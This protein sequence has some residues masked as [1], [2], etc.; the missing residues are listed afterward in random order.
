MKKTVLVVISF[1]LMIAASGCPM[2]TKPEQKPGNSGTTNPAKYAAEFLGEWI[3]MDTGDLWYI[4]GNSIKVNGAA[5]NMNV[6]LEKTSD[7]VITARGTNN[8]K[9][10]LFAS[11][12]PNASFSAEVVFLDGG[13]TQSSVSRDAIGSNGQKPPV[14]II[15]PKQPEQPPLKVQPDPVTGIIE[16]PG[17]IPGDPVIMTPDDPAWKNIN[18]RLTPG[19]GE[20]QYMGTLALTQGDN[21]KVSVRM[22]NYSAGITE[23]YADGVPREYIFEIENIA[24]SNCGDVGLKVEWDDED[25][26][27]SSGSQSGNFSNI[28]PGGKKEVRLTLIPKPIVPGYKTKEFK[29]TIRNYDSK[30]KKIRTWSDAVSVLYYK[31]PVPFR[32]KSLKTTQGI[33]KIKRDKA[34]GDGVSHYFK[35]TRTGDSGEYTATVLVPWSEEE[36]LIGFLGATIE[37]ESST[38]YS[39]GINEQPPSDWNSLDQ[40]DFLE[41]YKPDNEYEDRA[42]VLDLTAGEKTFMGFLAGDSIDYYKIRLGHVPPDYKTI[43]V[44]NWDKADLPDGY[45]DGYVNPG[46]TINLDLKFVNYTQ[47]NRTLTMTGLTPAVTH[48]AF[49]QDIRVPSY[50]LVLSAEHYG[51]LTSANTSTVS[52][53]VQLLYPPNI[54]R[55]FQFKLAPDCPIGPLSLTITFRDNLGMEYAQTVI[56]DVVAP[57]INIALDGSED[58]V[59]CGG[60]SNVVIWAKNTG[61]QDAYGVT[62][63]LVKPDS[64]HSGY[65]TINTTGT[66]SLGALSAG[67]SAASASFSVSVSSSCPAGVDIPLQIEFTNSEG[68]KWRANFSVRVLPPCPTNVRATALSENSVRISWDMVSGATNYKVYDGNSVL[69]EDVGTSTQYEHT[70]LAAATVY[71]YRVSALSS[72]NESVKSQVVS[73]KTWERLSFNREYGGTVSTGI[74]QYYRFNVTNSASYTFTSSVSASVKYETGDANWFNLSSGTVS[75]TASQSGWAYIKIENSV[76]TYSLRVDLPVPANVRAESISETSVRISWDQ[77]AGAAGYKVY[78]SAGALIATL[79]GAVLQYEHTSLNTGTVYSYRISA[80]IGSDESVRSAAVSART[81][82]RLVFN[83]QHSGTVSSGLP[84]YYRFNVTNG[85]NYAFTS[86]VSALVKYETGDANWFNLSSGTVSQTAG[87]TGWAYVKIENAGTYTLKVRNPE[88]AVSAFSINGNAGIV[89]E[90]DKTIAVNVPFGTNLTSLTPSVTA[91]SG[92][93]CTTTGAKN[94]TGPVEYSFAKGD[95]VQIY[96]VTVTPNGEGGIT[97]NPPPLTDISI[98]GFPVSA[99]TLSRTG[100]GG[101]LSTKT[102]TLTGSGYTSIEWWIGEVNKTAS[103]TNGGMVFA[104]QAASLTIG[105]HTLTVIVYKDGIP[106][107]NEIDFTVVQ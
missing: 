106:Y 43:D 7:N 65:L 70:G 81:W 12:I 102:V 84:H 38:K 87:Q 60:I 3:R 32:F 46:D 39:L 58:S 90:A 89:S 73:A 71:S 63:K 45:W 27:L 18:I 49:V 98:G 51:S 103:A 78:D 28:V 54:S 9:Y 62:A 47:E 2:G 93:T 41:M 23:L 8:S 77:V 26:I 40:W 96:S 5:S 34:K 25:F 56:M 59:A 13:S 75:Q 79:G 21:F 44:D 61:I 86:G 24:S 69:L 6:T 74:P 20:D 88:A 66:V 55:A 15:N 100:A 105:E 82:E 76:G 85:A 91:A 48:A 67:G 11:R 104:V 92:W 50:S 19:W 4:S 68:N 1:L 16:V 35:T 95:A 53:F 99:F 33:I 42:P 14:I 10:M 107:S 22:D 101:Y 97:I 29:F 36:Y 52:S 83:K 94:F 37:S 80:L 31:V 30:S 57:P 17:M 72:G 64:A